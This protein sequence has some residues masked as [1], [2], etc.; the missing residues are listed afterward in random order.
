MSGISKKDVAYLRE[1][2][3]KQMEYA[4]TPE[5]KMRESRWFAHNDLQADQPIVT[6]E[7]DTFFHEV[8]RPLICETED[9]RRFEEKILRHII[10]REDIDDDRATPDY[11]GAMRYSW[12]TPFGIEPKVNRVGD[13]S[14]HEYIHVIHDLE[15]DIE[16]LG[17]STWGYEKRSSDLDMAEEIFHGIMPVVEISEFPYGGLT[18]ML[19]RLISQETLFMSMYD[20]PDLVHKMMHML[21]SDWEKYYKELE[22]NGI[23]I[24]N[25]LNQPL[26][27][28][29]N[30]ATNLLTYKDGATI[31]DMWGYFDSQETVGLSP[32]MFAEFLFP[33]YKPLMDKCG[34]INY[35]CCEPVHF[36]WEKCL[37]RC[38]NLRK[39]S[40]SPW[41]DEVYMGDKL[42]GTSVIYHRK[43]SP[44]LLGE[45]EG[46]EDE[47]AKHIV[48]TLKA[49]KGCKLEFSLRDVYSIGGVKSRGKQVVRL[50]KRLIEAHWEG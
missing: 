42:R 4:N 2:A 49:A 15:R 3:K 14:A 20:Y 37:S 33:Y 19:I 36:F 8:A 44:N 40:I 45:K 50:I 5:N 32:D 11:F 7:E 13:T 17:A 34:L 47:Y 28:G 18:H 24:T 31:G 1:L 43:P 26:W 35:G 46:F 41:C 6:I 21:V 27:Q 29:T 10:G 22:E 16:K 38:Q 48:E 23:L 30:A 12:F 25:N 39:L 9:G